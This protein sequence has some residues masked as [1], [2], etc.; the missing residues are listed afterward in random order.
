MSDIHEFEGTVLTVIP[1]G[2]YEIELDNGHKIK[3]H[4]SGKIRK[5]NIRIYAGDKVKVE[6]SSSDLTKGRVT[7]RINTR[8]PR[9]VFKRR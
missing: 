8:K 2:E 9:P 6:M 3:G 5:F 1:G 4:A 7:F